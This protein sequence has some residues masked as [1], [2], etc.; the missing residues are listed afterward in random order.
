MSDFMVNEAR[1]QLRDSSSSTRTGLDGRERRIPKDDQEEVRPEAETHADPHA[2]RGREDAI[3]CAVN[4]AYSIKIEA[5]RKLGE[6]LKETPRNQGGNPKQLSTSTKREQVETPTLEELGVTRKEASIAQ[7]LA[8]LPK[9]QFE[10]VKAGHESI[11]RGGTVKTKRKTGKAGLKLEKDVTGIQATCLECG[12][13]FQVG[14]KRPQ[15][16]CPNKCNSE[17]K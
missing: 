8:S 3:Q 9:D 15:Y 16:I 14:T 4:Y 6:M 7:K 17:G 5:L 2:N 1:P 10:E 13:V 12:M 11:S